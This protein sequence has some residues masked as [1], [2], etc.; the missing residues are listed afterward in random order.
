[1][2]HLKPIPLSRLLQIGLCALWLT[3]ITF[4][5]AGALSTPETPT[6]TATVNIDGVTW[7]IEPDNTYERLILV[8]IGPNNVPLHMIFEADELPYL[9]LNS[10]TALGPEDG[11]Y[12]YE[13]KLVPS[14]TPEARELLALA[15][16][17]GNSDILTEAQDAGL[18]PTEGTVLSGN[19]TIDH[20]L[21]VLPDT[22]ET[23][24]RV[25]QVITDD[26]IVM[27]SACIG[28]DC[29]NGESFGF[30]TLRLKENNLRI[31]FQ[32]TSSTASFPTNDWRIVINDSANGGASYFA[33]EDANTARQPFR[34]EAGARANSLYVESDGDIGIGTSNPVVDLHIVCGDTP[35]TRLEQDSSYGWSPQ[36]WDIAG[37]ETNFFIRDATNGSQLPLRI[38]PSAPS[39]TLCLMSDGKV[40]IGTWS[41]NYG[42]ELETTSQ[43]ADL[44]LDRTDGAQL[45]LKALIDQGLIGTT[46]D[47]TLNF[48]TNDVTQ[49]TINTSGNVGI[50]TDNPAYKLDVVGQINASNG[51]IANGSV[52]IGTATPAYELDVVGQINASGGFISS[53]NVGIGTTSPAYELDVTGQIRASNGLIANGNVGIGTA[54]PAYELDVVGQI[55]ASEGFIA[56]SSR[57]LKQNIEE[58]TSEDAFKTFQKL[59][60]V[61]YQYKTNQAEN[62]IGFIAEEVP[63]MVAVN[64][65]KGLSS[66]DIV[67]VLT[68]V[69]QEQQQLIENQNRALSRMNRRLQSLELNSSQKNQENW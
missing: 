11:L 10:L 46:S 19:F 17:D 66:M 56:G 32:D 54:T 67:A 59:A 21:F 1:M 37:N 53:G 23:F 4:T 18:L 28:F 30:D 38:Q 13:L 50:G 65:R 57:D 35:T 22:S 48:A 36:T 33:I 55:K 3:I 5:P 68:K 49:M 63:A 6:I 60:P 42:L 45:L 29:N 47:H 41:P 9:G 51:F 25:D 8:V 16:E 40:G 44:F 64:G 24:Q 62:R 34:V 31:N 15:R 43:D 14:L 69:V 2:E 58:L 20:G 26:L 7:Q 39:N 52:G 12:K 27:G 61:T